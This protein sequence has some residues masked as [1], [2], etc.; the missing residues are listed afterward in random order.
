MESFEYSMAVH[1]GQIQVQNDEI[2][3]KIRL[4][5]HLESVFTIIRRIQ[6]D[7]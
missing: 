6:F 1:A 2:R 7:A 5:E 4:P 3:L